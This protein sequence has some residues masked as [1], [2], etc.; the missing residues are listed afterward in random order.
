MKFL[1]LENTIN[2]SCLFWIYFD[3]DVGKVGVSMSSCSQPHS[4]KTPLDMHRIGKKCFF[5]QDAFR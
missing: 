4:S 5:P 1:L 3:G 2:L